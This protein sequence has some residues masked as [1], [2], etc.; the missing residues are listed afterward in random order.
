[1][2]HRKPIADE[3][4]RLGRKHWDVPVQVDLKAYLRFS[5]RMARQL[6]RLVGQWAYT[7]T[8]T[9]RGVPADQAIFSDG[10]MRAE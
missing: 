5:R 1:M 9:A 8:P 3:P 10:P 6:R 7:A 4:V 2:N